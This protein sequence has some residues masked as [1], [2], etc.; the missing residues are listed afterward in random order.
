MFRSVIRVALA[1]VIFLSQPAQAWLA[2]YSY[3]KEITVQSA[4]IDSDLTDFPVYI[5]VTSDTDIGGGMTDTT[6]YYDF[7]ITNSSDTVIPYEVE[8]FNITTGTANA[9]IWAQIDPTAAGGQT[10]YFYYGKS[11]DTDG[12]NATGVWNA[13]YVGVW[14]MNDSSGTLTDSTS[15]ANHGTFGGDL[16][17]IARGGYISDAQDFDGTND[18]VDVGADASLMLTG[19]MTLSAW[20][21]SDVNAVADYTIISKQKSADF[22]YD[23]R[24]DQPSKF[25]VIVATG[26]ATQ[27]YRESLSE[28]G[29]S[30][31]YHVVGVFDPSTALNIYTN[32][33]LDNGTLS[34][35]V[36]AS[37]YNN[38][39]AP[40]IGTR[41]VSDN[42]YNGIIDEV[43][44]S[45][46]ARSA[47]WIK[48]EH[49]N[50]TEADNELTWGAE[51]VTPTAQIIL[52]ISKRMEEEFVFG[53]LAA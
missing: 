30:Q 21:F 32:G 37:Q 19:A 16:P 26:A 6:N 7:R 14:H 44:V 25:L 28:Y 35:S 47:D 43:R 40:H 9:D 11:G 4:N 15:N 48:F 2:G 46:A 18:T 23:L 33:A 1:L 22:G 13:N 24:Q 51:E 3:R 36:P 27:V 17:D 45:N 38:G 42:D 39:E 52:I 12:S 50:L 29:I 10:L 5:D 31:W 53:R 8:Y 41:P 34:A 49:A 20:V